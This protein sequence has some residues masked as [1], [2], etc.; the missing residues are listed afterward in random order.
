[1]KSEKTKATLLWKALIFERRLP[2]RYKIYLDFFNIAGFN[3]KNYHIIKD[4]KREMLKKNYNLND[5][6]NRFF[7][8]IKNTSPF[9]SNTNSSVEIHT[10]LC[11]RDRNM[12]I[13]AIKSFL[14]YY[15]NVKIIVH[16][17]GSLDK[18]DIFLLKKH[19][20]G[21]NI[22][23]NSDKIVNKFLKNKPYCKML[24]DYRVNA[25]QLFDYYV[26]AKNNKIISFDSDLIFLKKP[27]EIIEWIENKNNEIRYHNESKGQG[28]TEIFNKYKIK[29]VGGINCGFLCYYK[30]MM[31]YDLIEKTISKL[32]KDKGWHWS[33]GYFNLVAFKSKYKPSPLNEKKYFVYA[34]NNT[35]ITGKEVM[36]HFPA[37]IRFHD[38]KYNHLAK[39]VINELKK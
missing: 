36:I 30:D 26:F 27:N 11:K 16:S 13:L 9:K 5:I 34:N 35:N 4:Y 18:K 19:I 24:R 8:E 37:Y 15:N 20:I 7:S 17:D 31:N 21:I 33:Q 28:H 23:N 12:Y 25:K 10:I 3:I 38:F 6:S 39:K 1:M 2:W 22:I 29:E 14:R 32:K